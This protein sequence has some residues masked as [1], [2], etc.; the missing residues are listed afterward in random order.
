M[1]CPPDNV[2]RLVPRGVPSDNQATDQP[3]LADDL[4]S[5]ETLSSNLAILKGALIEQI[6]SYSRDCIAAGG[7][8]PTERL[9]ALLKP[10]A[11]LEAG[12]HRLAGAIAA[13]LP[14]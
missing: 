4:R 11:T 6:A 13:Q 2:V 5:L 12:M 7:T 14:R 1:G 10:V 8:D 9:S 3:R